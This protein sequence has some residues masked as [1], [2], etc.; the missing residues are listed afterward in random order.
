MRWLVLMALL[1]LP[2]GCAHHEH[3]LAQ[4]QPAAA[5]PGEIEGA[6]RGEPPQRPVQRVDNPLVTPPVP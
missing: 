3:N 2:L 5:P 4:R 6:K 1:T